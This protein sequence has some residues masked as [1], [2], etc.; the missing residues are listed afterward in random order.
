MGQRL[1]RTGAGSALLATHVAAAAMALTTYEEQTFADIFDE[2]EEPEA[3]SE[4][5]FPGNGDDPWSSNK[6]LDQIDLDQWEVTP[7]HESVP[8]DAEYGILYGRY[9]SDNQDETGCISRVKGMLDTA[10]EMEIPLYTDPVVDVAQSGKGAGRDG[11]EEIVR[12]VQHPQIQYFFVHDVDRI[13]RWNSFCIFLIEVFTRNFDVTVVTDDGE[14]DLD[15]LEGLATTWVTSMAG[16]I[17]NRNKAKRTLGGQIEQFV[18]GNYESWF[19]KIPI[20]YEDSEEK[21][22][23]KNEDEIEIVEAMFETFNEADES[24]PYAA[25]RDKINPQYGQILG[26][27]LT[28]DWLKEMLT[29]PIYIGKPTV[30]G[31]SIGDDGQEATLDKPDLQIIDE[32]LFEQVNEKIEKV[33]NKKS[34]SRASG[35]V[36]SLEYLMFEFGLLP[37]VESSP[38]VAVL[39]P[40]CES[41]MVR[42]GARDLENSERRA[43]IYKCMDCADHPDRTGTYKTYPNSLESYKIKLFDKVLSNLHEVANHFNLNEI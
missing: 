2:V 11:L 24:R 29:D 18:E 30:S 15:R 22:L 19:N 26:E 42:D 23:V 4:D 12:L 3:D 16:E 21:L 14:L 17:E 25:T 5:D 31:E 20:G 35:E 6:V 33:E 27:E 37:L 41:K 32:D 43:P 36:F 34:G 9:S 40:E 39:C 10:E 8:N 1:L 28:H 13:A 38:D 7:P